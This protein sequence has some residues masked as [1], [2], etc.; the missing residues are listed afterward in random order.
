MNDNSHP[1][2]PGNGAEPREVPPKQSVEAPLTPVGDPTLAVDL[3]RAEIDQLVQ[4]AHRFPRKITAVQDYLEA[5]VLHD[6]ATAE[7]AVYALPRAGKAIVGASIGFAN[8]VAAAW[9]N[10]WDYGR[11]I[12]TDRREKVVV[13]EGIFVDWQ[14]NRRLVITDQRRIVDK[15]GRLY[16]EDMI[17]VTS[18]ACTSIARRNAIL[19]GVPRPIWHPYYEKALYIVRGSAASLPERRDKAIKALANFGVDPKQVFMFLDVKGMDEIGVEHMPTLRGMFAALRDGSV[20]A[21]EMFD[22][23]KMTSTASFEQAGNPLGDDDAP[24]TTVAQEQHQPGTRQ[25]PAGEDSGQGAAS[26]APTQE[27]RQAKPSRGKKA[28]PK[29]NGKEAMPDAP[30][31]DATQNHETQPQPPQPEARAEDPDKFPEPWVRQSP[32]TYIAYA[33][34]WMANAKSAQAV[35]DRWNA[36]RNIRNGLSLSLDTDQLDRIRKVKAE[37]EKRLGDT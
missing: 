12:H 3:A 32:E 6:E 17:I 36:E 10:C 31:G 13:A 26:P 21:E 14:T 16:N 28:G 33:E 9:G 19:N 22:P 25:E 11:W 1:N 20:T 35:N 7:N 37:A 30:K 5:L 27:T 2:A 34:R 24:A 29:D 23:R 8:A 15:H 18:K 4:T